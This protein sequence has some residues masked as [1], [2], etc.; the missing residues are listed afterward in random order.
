MRKFLSLESGSFSENATLR[1]R[2][3]WEGLGRLESNA[4]AYSIGGISLFAG[5]VLVKLY[6]GVISHLPPE[7]V[8]SLPA[9]SAQFSDKGPAFAAVGLGLT[10]KGTVEYLIAALIKSG[11]RRNLQKTIFG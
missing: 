4:R 8:E 11:T 10:L 3:K 9:I 2:K 7:F 6:P 1:A 5:G